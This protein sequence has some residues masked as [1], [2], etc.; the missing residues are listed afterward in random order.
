VGRRLKEERRNAEVR[1]ANGEA[2]LD[3]NPVTVVLR[4]DTGK[5]DKLKGDSQ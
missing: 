1:S 4:V 3:M 5:K 2:E